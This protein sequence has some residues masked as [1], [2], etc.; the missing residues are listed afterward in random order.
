MRFSDGSSDVCSSDLET[1]ERIAAEG[2]DL[3]VVDGGDGT[4]RDVISAAPAAF[5]DRMPR[6]AILPSGQTNALAPAP[7]VPLEIGRASC[8]ERVC[9]YVS[10]SVV[11]VSL[12]T[13]T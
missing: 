11:A 9:Q 7:G 3:L 10:V 4:V 1:L 2:V 13:N 8:R 5:G 6:M 12:K